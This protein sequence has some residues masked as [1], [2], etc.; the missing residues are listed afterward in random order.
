V[1]SL[2]KTSAAIHSD[3]SQ[4]SSIYLVVAL[5][6]CLG[7]QAITTDLYL[8]SLPLIT[9]NLGT[10]VSK[11]QLTL[12]MLLVFFGLGQL[13]AGPLSDKFGR[14]PV[15]I[16]SLICYSVSAMAAS[17][18]DSISTLII[19]R[20]FQGFFMSGAVV[21]ARA[22]PRDLYRPDQAAALISK[23]LTGLG[24]IACLSPVIGA[25]LVSWQG[26]R[27]SLFALSIFGLISL[28]WIVIFQK[29]TVKQLNPN[30]LHL[31]TMFRNWL[32]IAKNKQFQA[33][34]ALSTSSYGA[35]FVF[36]ASSSFV[37][38]KVFG[39]D[40]IAY[41]F[42][43]IVS[44]ISYIA[45]TFLCRYLLR[46]HKISHAVKIGG[47]MSLIAALMFILISIIGISEVKY[48]I[49]FHILFMVAHGINL[50]CSTAGAVG[51]FPEKAGTAAALSGFI[52][53][54]V[55]FITGLILGQFISL[56]DP[57]IYP[58]TIGMAFWA[59]LVSFAALI[60]VQRSE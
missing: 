34:T 26:W 24:L 46:H 49:P 38:M 29:E 11:T 9:E 10:Q 17:A 1:S 20:S 57:T 55:A 36:L 58:L 3:P 7:I 6:L 12:S 45:G 15:L 39:H 40:S 13:I 60:L 8:P 42:W 33:F 16:G 25:V 48:F 4:H 27:A 30:A 21:C 14:R 22:L 18:A 47:W 35:L 31:P 50:P 53:M 19:W 32:S 37:F 43:L 2:K 52:M 51:P 56:S 54:L 41:G 23:G 44:S 5:A 28:I 59:S